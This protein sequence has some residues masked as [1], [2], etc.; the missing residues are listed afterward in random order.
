VALR[1]ALVSRALGDVDLNV[2]VSV[3]STNDVV[4]DMSSSWALA[5]ADEQTSGRGRLDRVWQSPLAAG[6]AMSVAFPRTDLRVP[7]TAV[8][9]VAGTAVVEALVQHACSARLKWPN[10]ILL[11]SEKKVGGILVSLHGE[12]V[13]VG[14]G[15]N[16]S[17]TES[18]LPTPVST[19]LS[20]EGHDVERESLIAEIVARLRAGISRDDWRKNYLAVSATVGQRVTVS[21]VDAQVIEGLCVDVDEDGALVLEGASGTERVTVGDVQHVRATT[22]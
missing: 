20:I 3:G 18:E 21:R 14:I 15:L 6:I 19:S 16:V 17:L 2:Q 22:A 12:R 13:V 8:P 11:G 1:S 5:T 4:L 9:L 7:L 10:D